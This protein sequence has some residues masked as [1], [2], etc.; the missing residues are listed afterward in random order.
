MPKRELA[1]D[2]LA[3][4]GLAEAPVLDLMCSH[5][6]LALAARQGSKFNVRRDLGS[7]FSLTGR[8]LAWPAPV[9]GRVRAFLARRCVDNDFWRGHEALTDAEFLERHGVWRGPYEEGTLFYHLDEYAK[10]APKDLLTL[11]STTGTWLARA[12]KKQATLVEKNIDALAGLLQLNR[13]ERAL[14]LRH[15]GALSAR[16]AHPAGRVQGQ[17]RT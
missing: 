15:T 10:D 6:V 4:P 13:A 12:L 14:L 2:V 8:H 3:S 11:L 17:Q 5:L 7:L 1:S 9:L 16:P